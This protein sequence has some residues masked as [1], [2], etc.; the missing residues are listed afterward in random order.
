MAVVL[1]ANLPTVLDLHRLWRDTATYSHGYL[2]APLAVMLWWSRRDLVSAMQ[3]HGR[4]FGVLLLA[5]A[6][7]GILIC[8]LAMFQTGAALLLPVALAAAACAAGGWHAAR[9]T[10]APL[11]MLYC[12]TPLASVLTAHL[13]WISAVVATAVCNLI[14]FP[15]ARYGVH[16]SIPGGGLFEVAAGCSGTNFLLVSLVMATFIGAWHRLAMRARLGILVA[17][18]A[19]ALVA[20]WLRIVLLVIVGHRHGMQHPLI[21]GEHYALGWLLFAGSL[22]ALILVVERRIHRNPAS[23]ARPAPISMATPRNLV[24]ACAI[25]LLGPAL[26]LATRLLPSTAQAVP[27]DLALAAVSGCEGPLPASS[28]WNPQFSRPDLER[29]AEYRCN[30]QLMLVYRNRYFSQ[31]PGRELISSENEV[32]PSQWQLQGMPTSPL[33][34]GQW[35]EARALDGTR[36]L[37]TFLYEISDYRG[38][39]ARRIKWLQLVGRLRGT[40]DQG[41]LRLVATRCVT[42]CSQALENLQEFV[43]T[44]RL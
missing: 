17:A 6:S 20:N 23:P 7:V 36:W 10:A 39:D 37:A 22:V 19:V 3:P 26:L 16:L 27:V 24:L 8:Q 13:Q 12:A 42:D 15:T 40:Q 35:V 34:Q 29:I 41:G 33:G 5:A 31:E 4:V 38:V 32:L 21:A 14:G 2:T 44:S 30:D 43:I 28:D 9:W 18:V 25:A 11:A 1:I